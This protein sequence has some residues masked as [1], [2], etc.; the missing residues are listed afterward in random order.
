M[1]QKP[2]K[3]N[4]RELNPKRIFEVHAFGLPWK[5]A[6][7]APRLGNRSVFILDLCLPSNRGEKTPLTFKPNR[8]F[9]GFTLIIMVSA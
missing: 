6:P 7:P 5:L 9:Q 1:N 4:F 3:G 2:W 8:S